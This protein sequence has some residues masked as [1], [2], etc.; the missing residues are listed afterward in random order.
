V[1]QAVAPAYKR[2]KQR[3]TYQRWGRDNSRWLDTTK[4]RWPIVSSAD[5]EAKS[6]YQKFL[7]LAPT[8]SLGHKYL[9]W[10]LATCPD[11]KLRDPVRAVQLAQRALELEEQVGNTWNTLGVAHYRAGNWKAAIDALDKSRQ[12]RKGGDAFDFYFLAMSYWKLGQ[13]DEARRWY[14]QAV[15][16]MEKNND[17]LMKNPQ[18]PEELRR[19]RAETEQILGIGKK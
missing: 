16:W 1:A 7:E 6:D 12:H 15:E 14:N 11:A 17:E 10:L 19:F 9:S 13:K 8:S 18:W 5:T 4:G 2:R 3:P